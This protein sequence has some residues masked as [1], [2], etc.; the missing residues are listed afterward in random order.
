[1][2]ARSEFRPKT[3]RKGTGEEFPSPGTSRGHTVPGIHIRVPSP[4]AKQERRSD[5]SYAQSK[6]NR[7]RA[8]HLS[9]AFFCI[10]TIKFSASFERDG[11][12]PRSGSTL[13]DSIA[14][15]SFIRERRTDLL[16][17]LC[18]HPI[19]SPV[20]A[21]VSRRVMKFCIFIS[22][23]AH[24]R[25]FRA[26]EP[27]LVA[28][29]LAVSS[30]IGTPFI[31]QRLEPIPLRLWQVLFYQSVSVGSTSHRSLTRPKTSFTLK[32]KTDLKKKFRTTQKVTI[33]PVSQADV[34]ASI[35]AGELCL[36]QHRPE[37]RHRVSHLDGKDYYEHIPTQILY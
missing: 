28:Q 26:R 16:W 7:G 36:V 18:M 14:G 23:T 9:C 34:Q 27:F 19:Q 13:W 11:T 3:A 8:Q 4:N 6:C 5:S 37:T 21:V 10:E 2:A 12:V 17:H 31:V 20:L 32:Y 15:P 30:L 29:I 22:I 35:P 33:L 1:M 24:C 25:E